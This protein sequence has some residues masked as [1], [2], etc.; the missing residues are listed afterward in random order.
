[1]NKVR[2]TGSQIRGKLLSITN[3]LGLPSQK[4]L[5][6]AYKEA[7]G[8]ITR[9]TFQKHIAEALSNHELI[10]IRKNELEKTPKE[11][12]L[13]LFLLGPAA[14]PAEDD[15]IRI[16]ISE[17]SLVPRDPNKYLDWKVLAQHTWK[18]YIKKAQT[19]LNRLKSAGSIP[20]KLD[21]EFFDL[22]IK[23]HQLTNWLYGKPDVDERNQASEILNKCRMIV[24]QAS[25]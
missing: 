7:Y 2:L 11:S 23:Y 20:K 12:G 17:L 8:K 10:K 16:A 25:H 18:N 22:S 6:Q 3:Y 24:K 5:Y 1:M 15:E 13:P 19:L 14:E 9:K 21:L 4:E